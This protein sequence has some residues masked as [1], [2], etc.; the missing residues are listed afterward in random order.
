VG[1]NIIGEKREREVGYMRSGERGL[2]LIEVS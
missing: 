1:R 2:G